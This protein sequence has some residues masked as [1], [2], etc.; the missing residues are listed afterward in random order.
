VASGAG[1]EQILAADE[2]FSTPA[3]SV[4]EGESGSGTSGYVV[5]GLLMVGLVAGLIF[6]RVR[7]SRS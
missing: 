2:V 4:A 3:S 5:F 6:L 1:S 7:E